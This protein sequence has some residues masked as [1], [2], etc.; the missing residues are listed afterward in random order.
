MHFFG[1]FDIGNSAVSL[2]DGQN[3]DVDPI[4]FVDGRHSLS[5]HWPVCAGR[6]DVEA[7]IHSTLFTREFQQK[8]LFAALTPEQPT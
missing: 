5:S 3:I 2:Q 4:K 1:K 8:M 6:P 7:L